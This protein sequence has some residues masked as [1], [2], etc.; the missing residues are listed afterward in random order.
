MLNGSI[1]GPIPDIEF[2]VVKDQS[3]LIFAV[4]IGWSQIIRVEDKSL[5]F[6]VSWLRSGCC[7]DPQELYFSRKFG[8][9]LENKSDTIVRKV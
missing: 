1:I 9:I 6:L 3:V 7:Y 5:N 8:G 4:A 2:D